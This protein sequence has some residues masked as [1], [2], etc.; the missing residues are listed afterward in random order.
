M[1]RGA[2]LRNE[3]DDRLDVEADD[4]PGELMWRFDRMY[5]SY[6][7]LYGSIDRLEEDWHREFEELCRE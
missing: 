7:V 6:E 4:P 5:L 1:D 3:S 2:D